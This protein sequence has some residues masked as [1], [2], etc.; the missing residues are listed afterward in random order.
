MSLTRRRE[1]RK[2]AESEESGK[3]RKF[4]R[5]G[6]ARKKTFSFPSRVFG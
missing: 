1:I 4:V 3:K 6:F 5:G 2:I